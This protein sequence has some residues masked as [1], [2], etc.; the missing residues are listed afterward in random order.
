MFDVTFSWMSSR[1]IDSLVVLEFV[2]VTKKLYIYICVGYK[3]KIFTKNRV[4]T[5]CTKVLLT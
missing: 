5:R 4:I 2:E 1:K 3:Q